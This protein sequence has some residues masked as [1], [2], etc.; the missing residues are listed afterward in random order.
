M[1]CKN[2]KCGKELTGRGNK[3]F[4][5]EKCRNAFHAKKLVFLSTKLKPEQVREIKELEYK[6]L[7]DNIKEVIESE[8][9]ATL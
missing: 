7:N 9:N 5:D 3:K 1:H 8:T 6:F 2:E 4:C